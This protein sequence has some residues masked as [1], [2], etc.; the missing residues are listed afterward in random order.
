[1]LLRAERSGTGNGRVYL[2]T[3]TATENQGAS[4]TG[5]V[6]VQV[7][8]E[9]LKRGHAADRAMRRRQAELRFG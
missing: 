9:A 4:V 2:L 5:T 3:F 1:M 6:K 7:P 8:R